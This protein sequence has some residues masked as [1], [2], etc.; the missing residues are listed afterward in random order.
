MWFAYHFDTVWKVRM[1]FKIWKNYLLVQKFWRFFC[2]KMIYHHIKFVNNNCFCCGTENVIGNR[3]SEVLHTNFIHL[4]SQFLQID[5]IGTGR[6]CSSCFTYVMKFVAIA[7]TRL[8]NVN[9]FTCNDSFLRIFFDN[10][11]YRLKWTVCL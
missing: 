9:I 8:L 2:Q 10:P 7:S 3:I 11:N 4:F 6:I 5:I 1:F